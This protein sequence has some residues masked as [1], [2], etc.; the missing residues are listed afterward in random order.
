[1][2]LSEEIVRNDVRPILPR[3]SA[4]T[5]ILPRAFERQCSKTAFVSFVSSEAAPQTGIV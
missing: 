3:R 4:G 5:Q 2:R 1:M